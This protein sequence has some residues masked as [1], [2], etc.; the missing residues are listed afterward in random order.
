MDLFKGVINE[1]M[2]DM[3]GYEYQW[4]SL[5]DISFTGNHEFYL[6]FQGLQPYASKQ[7][8]FPRKTYYAILQYPYMPYFVFWGVFF[9]SEKPSQ[10]D[11]ESKWIPNWVDPAGCS[12]SKVHSIAREVAIV[13][14]FATVL[15]LIFTWHVEPIWLGDVRCEDDI[16]GSR[17]KSSPRLETSKVDHQ[18][19]W[20]L[21]SHM[22]GQWKSKSHPMQI[23]M[24][25]GMENW[26]GK[27]WLNNFGVVFLLKTCDAYIRNSIHQSRQNWKM[28]KCCTKGSLVG[29]KIRCFISKAL[30]TNVFFAELLIQTSHKTI[31][32]WYPLVN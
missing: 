8:W 29:S 14:S 24:V 2:L 20:N 10:N 13:S 9:P 1:F 30:K 31:E 26:H 17:I 12:H 11:S 3:I 27:K 5:K 18:A 16:F 19:V 28:R 7:R 25:L 6:N 21:Q 22:A 23:T 15:P 4:T 32:F